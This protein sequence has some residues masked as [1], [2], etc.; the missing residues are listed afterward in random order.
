MYTNPDQDWKTI[1][2]RF[3]KLRHD[4]EECSKCFALGRYPASLFHVLLVAEFGIIEVA[5]LLNVV[6]NRPGWGDLERLERVHNKKW[7][8]KSLL[9]QQHS[10]F[11][12][13]LLPLAF[14]IKD[15]WR[16]KISHVENKLEWMNTDFS[17]QVA[18]EIISATRGFM[19]R[20]A[21]D[22]P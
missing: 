14:A 4:V 17:S 19:R 1:I 8:E 7:A 3:P 2:R 6:G 10:E 11:L 15:S 20:L 5:K 18:S 9:E 21:E 13:N 12:K 22:L 16:H